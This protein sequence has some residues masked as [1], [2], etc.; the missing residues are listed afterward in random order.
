[1][2]NTLRRVF[3][4]SPLHYTVRERTFQAAELNKHL[5]SIAG[6]DPRKCTVQINSFIQSPGNVILTEITKAPTP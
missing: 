6:Y 4:G 1:M 3:F 2:I 5:A